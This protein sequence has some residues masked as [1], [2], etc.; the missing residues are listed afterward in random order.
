MV[1]GDGVRGIERRDLAVAT[2]ADADIMR[3][4]L[5][6]ALNVFLID[7]FIWRDAEV[8]PRG[9]TM[10]ASVTGEQFDPRRHQLIEEI[11]AV[12]YHRLAVENTAAGWRATVVFDA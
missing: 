2:G 8:T 5:A 4:L 10:V 7:G 3:D 11:K 9:K 1:E 12:T 6:T